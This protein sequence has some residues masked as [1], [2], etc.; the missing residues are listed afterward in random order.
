MRH[1][2]SSGLGSQISCFGSLLRPRSSGEGAT[3]GLFGGSVALGSVERHHEHHEQD[4]R[5][6]SERDR[7]HANLESVQ[8]FE[9]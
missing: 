5:P 7:R 4:E 9:I 8:A 3:S 6:K 2:T 1:E